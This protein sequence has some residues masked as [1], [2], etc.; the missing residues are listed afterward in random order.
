ME[1]CFVQE[2]QETVKGM[3]ET[4]EKRIRKSYDDA[5]RLTDDQPSELASKIAMSEQVQSQSR[6]QAQDTGTQPA[7]VGILTMEE[8]V[9][10]ERRKNN[11]VLY[12]L[13]ES[14]AS[15]NQ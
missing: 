15:T 2:F 8:V 6:F 14:K 12:N 9:D 4:G 1:R 7:A 5:V 11:I 3:T 13:A 10:R